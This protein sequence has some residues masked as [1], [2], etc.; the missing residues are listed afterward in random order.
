M[1]AS[2]PDNYHERGDMTLSGIGQPIQKPNVT[3]SNS[4]DLDEEGNGEDVN[5]YSH[6]DG[7]SE[8]SSIEESE[9]LELDLIASDDELNDE[10]TG[11]TS[12]ERRQRWLQRGRRRRE[13]DAEIM[14]VK[15]SEHGR[16]QAD[17]AVIKRLGINAVLIG[18]WYIFSVAI[19]MV[20]SSSQRACVILLG[21]QLTRLCLPV[22]SVDVLVQQ[23]RFS[24]PAFRHQP[25]YDCSIRSV[26]PPALLFP[27]SPPKETTVPELEDRECD[28]AHTSHVDMVLCHQAYS[29]RH[30]NITRCGLGKH[31]PEIHHAYLLHHVQVLCSSFRAPLCFPVPSGN[32]IR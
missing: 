27:F 12:K 21:L 10:E 32:T 4:V 26:V 28:Q 1:E 19:S 23:S 5:L 17:V 11:L 18:L 31:V 6:E 8:R 24:I 25:A 3:G 15:I 9:E 13:P 30:G 14:D 7:R 22:Q 16:H 20:S 2:P 29:L